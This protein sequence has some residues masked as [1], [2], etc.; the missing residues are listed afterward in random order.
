MVCGAIGGAVAIE[1]ITAHPTDPAH[2]PAIVI[3]AAGPMTFMAGNMLFRRT[4]GR[5]IPASSLT[6]FVVPR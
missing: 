6:P 4:L 1:E 3:A 5:S 2:L